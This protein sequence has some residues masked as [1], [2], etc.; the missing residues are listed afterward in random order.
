MTA[1]RH[2]L[3]AGLLGLILAAQ[4]FAS[5]P[6][7]SKQIANL[8]REANRLD[9][10]VMLM[11]YKQG[12]CIKCEFII[13]SIFRSLQKTHP[14]IFYVVLIVADRI[15]EAQKVIRGMQSTN[16]VKAVYLADNG[17]LADSCHMLGIDPLWAYFS[18]DDA[19]V[20][21]GKIL[22]GLGNTS[23]LSGAYS[24][25]RNTPNLLR[26]ESVIIQ[27]DSNTVLTDLF[28]TSVVKDDFLGIG[29]RSSNRGYLV[30]M[31]SGAVREAMEITKDHLK[32]ILENGESFLEEAA[33]LNVGNLISVQQVL[34]TPDLGQYLVYG[35]VYVKKREI[36]FSHRD[37]IIGVYQ[38][39]F[40]VRWSDKQKDLVSVISI[41]F[42]DNPSFCQDALLL[43]S[44]LFLGM[45]YL[46]VDEF[47]RQIRYDSLLT[48]MVVNSRTG[49]GKYVF[50]AEH[51]YESC[52]FGPS[53]I[54][55]SF[56]YM[57]GKVYMIQSLG[58][59]I[60]IYG[61][62]DSIPVSGDHYSAPGKYLPDQLRERVKETG[63]K[64]HE[65]LRHELKVKTFVQGLIPIT[66]RFL[67]MY[68][69]TS[70]DITNRKLPRSYYMHIY[71]TETREFIVNLTLPVDSMKKEQLLKVVRSRKEY[72]GSASFTLLIKDDNGFRLDT[73]SVEN[74]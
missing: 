64:S 23:F 11:T 72:S 27:E 59:S 62:K 69:V 54:A 43:D 61:S 3:L 40:L 49:A 58:S 4:T 22:D 71:N 47:S 12:N 24:P 37:T 38:K 14:D 67:G 57:D 65:D 25:L 74:L 5:T 44:T 66:H 28:T 6:V 21:Y 13:Q 55:T 52:D 26:K 36:D 10:P 16:E 8:L 33:A 29:D 42:A 60:H 53:F 2:I 1:R 41:P 34:F 20:R 9:Q 17:E 73:Y 31:K 39:P 70:E 68:F 46:L 48:A 45:D 56:A 30:D 15:K 7:L 18:H 51:F 32:R 35:T 50:P 63:I 19:L